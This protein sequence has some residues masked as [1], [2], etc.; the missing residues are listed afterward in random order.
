MRLNHIFRAYHVRA[1][2]VAAVLATL[3][4]AMT[5]DAQQQRRAVALP[6]AHMTALGGVEVGSPAAR[7]RLVEYVSYTCGHCAHYAEESTA[8][9]RSAYVG[10]GVVSVE[11]RNLVRDPIDVTAASIAHCGAVAGYPRRHAALMAGQAGYFER[12]RSVPQ[13]QISAMGDGSTGAQRQLIASGTGMLAV[14]ARAGVPAAAANR[15]LAD[16]VIAA[17]I[18]ALR[19]AAIAAGVTGTPSFQLNGTLL[20][21]HNWAALQ[22]QLDAAISAAH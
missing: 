17:R 8:P 3:A 1:L 12:L 21:A 11:T 7:V 2:G 4:G 5:A 22:P 18:E 20:D 15:C 10:R 9:L 6:A 13:A 16:P 14:A 19:Q